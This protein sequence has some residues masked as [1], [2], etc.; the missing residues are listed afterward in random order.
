M[1]I[2]NDVISKFWIPT[3]FLILSI[4]LILEKIRPNY[5]YGVRLKITYS[6][7]NVWYKANKYFGWHLLISGILLIFYRLAEPSFY[8]LQNN[9]KGAISILVVISILSL[10]VYLYRIKE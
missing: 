3:L 5:I 7:E 1:Q 8:F 2:E 10:S 6:N 9:F 4:P